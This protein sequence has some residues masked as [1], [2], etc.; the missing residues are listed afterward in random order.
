M[1]VAHLRVFLHAEGVLLVTADR[2]SHFVHWHHSVAS[3]AF[4]H[5]QFAHGGLGRGDDFELRETHL[6][7]HVGCE[8]HLLPHHDEGPSRRADIPQ[9][10]IGQV[11]VV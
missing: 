6:E 5:V 4:K 3:R 8:G 11:A 7:H 2:E 9:V 1:I 10:K